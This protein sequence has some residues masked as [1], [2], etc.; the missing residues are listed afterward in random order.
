M[1]P[2]HNTILTELAEL[3]D[4]REYGHEVKEMDL[5]YAKENGAVIVFGA[6]DDLIIFAGAI[7]DGSDCYEGSVIP[8]NR[9]GVIDCECDSMNC[10]YFNGIKDGASAV[11]ACWDSGEYSWTYETDIPHETFE[12]LED[13]EKYC[14]GIVF[15][16][17]D[18][19]P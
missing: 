19:K 9:S 11:V 12:I 5:K 2:T 18:V 8:F 4:G 14:R 15:L 1:T 6:S 16:L 7:T 13:G 3:L 17:E 10:P